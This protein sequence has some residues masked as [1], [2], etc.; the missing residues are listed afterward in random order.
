MG[1]AAMRDAMARPSRIET[2]AERSMRLRPL[3]HLG[4]AV[5]MRQAVDLLD[6]SLDEPD[7]PDGRDRA[8]LLVLDARTTLMGLLGPR[9][10]R[11]P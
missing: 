10:G 7:T 4:D 5:A 2:T 8:S 11:G 1:W 6:R 3:L 9:E